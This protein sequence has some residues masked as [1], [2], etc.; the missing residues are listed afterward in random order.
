MSPDRSR[1][2]TR[3]ALAWFALATAT[4]VWPIYPRYF[5]S[6]EPRILGLPFS[7]AWILI[8][9]IA[10]FLAVALLYALHLVDDRE[11]DEGAGS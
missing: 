2:A 6:I 9:I 8:V 10:N 11:H 3:L 5:D 4:L 1:V 7:L